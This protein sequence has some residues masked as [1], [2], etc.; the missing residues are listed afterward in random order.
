MDRNIHATKAQTHQQVALRKESV[1]RNSTASIMQ[2]QA[3]A[4]LSARRAW[5]EIAQSLTS[6]ANITSLSARRAWIEI[7]AHC[8]LRAHRR[9]ALR[10]ESVDRN[11]R[12]PTL[13]G[14]RMWSLSARRAWI[15]IV[16]PFFAVLG[17]WVA[18][19]KESVDRNFNPGRAARP[20][21]VALR[22]ESVD[23]NRRHED[24]SLRL[25]TSLSARRA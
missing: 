8:R 7:A 17:A 14:F 19:R 15:E 11:T 13:N 18:L 20:R 10:K 22:K 24:G 23:R 2:P 5:I 4:S 3:T 25:D 6:G 1:D 12:T 9:V 21:P 16:M